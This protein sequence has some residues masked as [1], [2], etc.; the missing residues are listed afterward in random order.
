MSN[1]DLK[2]IHLTADRSRGWRYSLL[3]I[4]LAATL[5][6][7][8]NRFVF[9]QNT[10]LLQYEFSEHYPETSL[11]EI[12]QKAVKE[13]K[14]VSEYLNV[15]AYSHSAAR[16]SLGFAV[17]ALIFGVLADVVSIRIL[18]PIVVL[19]WSL[20]GALTGTVE[21]VTGLSIARFFLGVFEAAHWPCALRTTQ[22]TFLPQERTT[23][24]GILQSGASIGAVLAPLLVWYL[25]VH[26]PEN[27]RGAFLLVGC[28]GIPWAVAWLL[29]VRESDVL[30][31][32]IQTDE[33]SAGK[34]EAKVMEEI[35][36]WNLFT[37]RRWWVLLFTV[38]CI[39][40][41]WHFIRVWMTDW[42]ENVHHYEHEF[43]A[44]FTSLYFLVTFFG[45]LASGAAISLLV[46]RGWNVQRARVIVFFVF[47]LL[48]ALVIPAAFLPAGKLLLGTLLVVAFGSLGLFPIYYSLNQELSAR[49]QGKVG[50]TLGFSTWFLLFFFHGWIGDLIK[51]YPASRTVVFCVVGILPLVAFVV[52]WKF[53]GRRPVMERAAQSLTDENG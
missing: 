4:L 46:N 44:G 36:F 28:C 43:V 25:A 9:T 12:R 47:A 11:E 48:T 37:T 6:N 23:G 39:N 41:V 27:W 34:G 15:E 52:L 33:T 20:A 38:I 29:T 7:Y 19:G 3:L 2:G 10:T 26:D 53:W 8:A 17:G 30:R 14:S 21:T 24:N 42:L 22:R 16:F 51:G 32:V 40:T 50:G 31:P 1:S 35:P 49:H 45:A 5:L 18:Y 13:E